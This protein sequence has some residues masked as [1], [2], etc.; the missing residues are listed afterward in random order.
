MDEFRPLLYFLKEEI[1]TMDV[2][3]EHDFLSSD[4]LSLY[5]DCIEIPRTSDHIWIYEKLTKKCKVVN[6]NIYHFQISGFGIDISKKTGVEQWT[7]SLG[8]GFESTFKMNVIVCTSDAELF[9]NHG[10]YKVQGKRGTL[11]IFPSYLWWKITG[12]FIYTV[13]SGDPFR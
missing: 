4:D 3:V 6:E 8:S 7:L 10:S 11:F 9:I 1:N 12:N 5:D 2:F 13:L